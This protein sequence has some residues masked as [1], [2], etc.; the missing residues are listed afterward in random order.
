MDIALFN[1]ANMK[2][3]YA[4]QFVGLTKENIKLLAETYP[5]MSPDLLIVND[6]DRK[7]VSVAT[8]KSLYSLLKLGFDFRIIATKFGD[9]K[10]TPVS[11]QIAIVEEEL[12]QESYI[13]PD[14]PIFSTTKRKPMSEDTKRKISESRKRNNL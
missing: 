2:N 1:P 8:Y 7:V 12:K 6:K 14:Q 9:P 5:V 3:L 4:S 13:E 10:P 11:E